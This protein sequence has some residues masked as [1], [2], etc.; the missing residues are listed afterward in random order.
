MEIT[1]GSIIWWD[2]VEQGR[3]HVQYGRRPVIV[4]S[5]DKCNE[6]SGVITVVPCT[7]RVTIAYP[8]QVPLVFAG[9]VSIALTDQITSVPRGELD[10]VIGHLQPFQLEQLDKALCVQL[11]L[12]F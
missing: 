12:N 10:T 5:N 8:Q 3:G 7:T 6:A 11:G 2:G 1:R 9:K 4:V